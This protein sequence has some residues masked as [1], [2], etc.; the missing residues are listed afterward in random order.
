MALKKLVAIAFIITFSL[1]AK[2]QEK[3]KAL[4]FS[5]GL[6]LH[7]V[8]FSYVED[9]LDPLEVSLS[10]T[11]LYMTNPAIRWTRG[12]QYRELGV[13]GVTLT[14]VTNSTSNNG[15]WNVQ[16]NDLISLEAYYAFGF[17]LYSREGLNVNLSVEPALS[18]SHA[19]VYGNT[20]DE[21]TPFFFTGNSVIQRSYFTPHIMRDL[22]ER[23]FIDAAIAMSFYDASYQHV[24][25][26][27]T[28]LTLF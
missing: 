24:D 18:Y 3:E 28:S 7:G 12:K 27:N 19:A 22:G 17:T 9:G 25:Y 26:S 8:S 1:V 15:S 13:R 5:S 16:S 21:A 14:S 20:L 6:S 23:I 2:A 11:G 10:G 4:L